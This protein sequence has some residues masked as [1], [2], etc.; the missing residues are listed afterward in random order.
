MGLSGAERNSE[1]ELVQLQMQRMR[2]S[3][4][5]PRRGS[6]SPQK[7]VVRILVETSELEMPLIASNETTLP[8]E[9]ISWALAARE[10]PRQDRRVKWEAFWRLQSQECIAMAMEI[11][12]PLQSVGE[13]R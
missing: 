6:D 1:E 9:V 7:L 3:M 2:M 11:S 12:T 8:N 10:S 13:M 5:L 4:R